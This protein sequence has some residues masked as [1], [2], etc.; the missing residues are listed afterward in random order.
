MTRRLPLVPTII[1]VLMLPVLIALGIWQLSRADWKDALLERLAA[2]PQLPSVEL[3]RDWSSDLDF[4][5]AVVDC[6]VDRATPIVRA[7]RSTASI[8]GYS[9][10]VPCRMPGTDKKLTLDAGWSPRPDTVQTV[11]AAGPFTGLL[12]AT[13]GDGYILVSAN[14]VPSLVPSAP[15]SVDEIPN[16]HMSYAMQWFFFAATLTVIYLIYLQ[17]WRRERVRRDTSIAADAAER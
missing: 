15:P 16:N 17:Q 2:A 11:T 6:V 1:T 5:R 8:P 9:Y 10:F 13:S 12:R 14:P 4:R 7:G 3:P